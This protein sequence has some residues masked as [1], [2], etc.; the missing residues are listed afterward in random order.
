MDKIF[1]L[2]FEVDVVTAVEVVTHVEVFV[3]VFVVVLEQSP[4]L[5]GT[6]ACVVY[7]YTVGEHLQTPP[8]VE[9]IVEEVVLLADGMVLGTELDEL[10]LLLSVL[11][12]FKDV[13]LVVELLQ[14]DVEVRVDWVDV[15]VLDWELERLDDIEE[16]T[17]DE[18]DVW[19]LCTEL[20]ELEDDW[21]ILEL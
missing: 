10:W 11:Q 15:C 14:V 7:M 18:D 17:V 8:D 3:T 12:G 1:S 21:V 6:T 2:V 9:D 13:E 19:L 16:D 5:F 20:D 4:G